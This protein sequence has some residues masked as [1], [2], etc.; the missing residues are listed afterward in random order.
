MIDSPVNA[1][2]LQFSLSSFPCGRHFSFTAAFRLSC[3]CKI[4]G[5]CI[6]F[7][8]LYSNLYGIGTNGTRTINICF[9]RLYSKLRKKETARTVS[10]FTYKICQSIYF[11]YIT[12]Y[13]F[14][15]ASVLAVVSASAASSVLSSEAAVA[16][17]VVLS[18]EAAVASSAVLSSEAAAVS[19]SVLSA[20]VDV[21]S[22]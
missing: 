1:Y 17:S 16:S 6:R 10:F 9:I 7:I 12:Y 21:A 5:T 20:S 4:S 2:N 15:S 11:F 13:S 19:S 22:V 3:I 8:K 14:Y 18:S